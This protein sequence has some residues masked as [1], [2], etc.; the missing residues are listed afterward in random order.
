MEITHLVVSGCSWTYCQGLVD[1]K[2]QGWPSFL[3]RKLGVPVVNLALPGLGN[4]AIHR[5]TY[6]YFFQ[7]LP[8]NSKP[9]YII[10]WSQ[11]WRK[12]EW[13]RHLYSETLK[14]EPGY[15]IVAM[16][17]SRPKNSVERALLDTWSEED[18]YRRTMLYR[19]S[20][21][22][23]FKS[24]NI[25]HLTSFFFDCENQDTPPIRNKYKSIV[26]YLDNNT[27]TL[28]PYFYEITSPYPNLPCGHEGYESMPVLADYIYD[29]LIKYYKEIK[30][31]TGKFM[32]LKEFE[33]V[34][35]TGVV[36]SAW[37]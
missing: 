14:L 32:T 10:A 15:S 16:P 29:N 34:D 12:E 26:N 23:L 27:N 7:D 18:F 25:P 11:T 31:V 22:S 24:K 35:T 19:L 6:E 17:D 33:E 3:A 8:N 28:K 36:E 13:C 1:P 9:V 20:L 37:K 5:R 21:D 2:T 30:P 4:D